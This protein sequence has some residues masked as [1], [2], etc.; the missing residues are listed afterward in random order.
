MSLILVRISLKFSSPCS[1]ILLL[2]RFLYYCTDKK[3]N[4]WPVL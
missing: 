1:F 3:K 2:F 4:I